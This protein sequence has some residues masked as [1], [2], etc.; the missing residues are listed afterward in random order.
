MF[1]RF[2]SGYALA[3]VGRMDAQK[4][5]LSSLASQLKSSM[6]AS[7]AIDLACSCFGKVKTDLTLRECV[8]C[9]KSLMSVELS[10]MH[11]ATLPG[12]SAEPQG[13]GAWYYILSH[14]GCE[15]AIGNYLADGEYVGFDNPEQFTDSKREPIEEIYRRNISPGPYTFM[16]LMEQGVEVE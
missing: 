11:M 9:V 8:S 10:S 16:G 14:D 3:D 7:R 1:V 15:S 4:L 6:T 12:A 2:R 13:G 5:F